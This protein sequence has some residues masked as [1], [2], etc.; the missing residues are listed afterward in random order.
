MYVNNLRVCDICLIK[1]QMLPTFRQF[2]ISKMHYACIV[3]M[4]CRYAMIINLMLKCFNFH[5]DSLNLCL[6]FWNVNVT[7]A[8]T[9]LQTTLL[10]L[11]GRHIVYLSE[12]KCVVFFQSRTNRNILLRILRRNYVH[13]YIH[14]RLCTKVLVSRTRGFEYCSWCLW[15]YN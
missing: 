11:F 15:F 4:Y 6:F 12:A 7:R 9:V 2:Q 5:S 14:S 3:I 13:V 1:I 10:T 8:N